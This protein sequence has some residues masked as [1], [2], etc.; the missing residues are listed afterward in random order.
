[1]YVEGLSLI[2][3]HK[4]ELR[5]LYDKTDCVMVHSNIVETNITTLILILPNGLGLVILYTMK[6]EI[7]SVYRAIILI[8]PR[9]VFHPRRVFQP[10][11][12]EAQVSILLGYDI[13]ATFYP[14]SSDIQCIV[15]TGAW[16]FEESFL[17]PRFF[18]PVSFS[19]CHRHDILIGFHHNFKI[20]MLVVAILLLQPEASE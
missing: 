10:R 15:Y 12:Y 1:M 7:Q 5:C 9:R 17:I 11:P 8:N 14:Q 6:Y 2:Y 3:Y 13:M 20:I 16:Q 4:L 18:G 19:N